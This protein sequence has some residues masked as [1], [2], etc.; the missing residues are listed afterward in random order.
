MKYLS[1]VFCISIS[2]SLYSQ[3][4]FDYKQF[5]EKMCSPE[6]QGRGYVNSGDSIAAVF[7]A[8]QLNRLGLDS[9]STGYFQPFD[10]KVNTFPDTCSVFLGGNKLIPGKD[11]IVAPISGGS[12]DPSHCAPKLFNV[13]FISGKNFIEMKGLNILEKLHLQTEDILVIDN[14][15]YSS[16]STREISYL[17]REYARKNHVIEAVSNKF[18]WSVT[19]LKNEHLYLQMKAPLFQN[20]IKGL[21]VEIHLHN[22]YLAPHTANNVLGFIPSRKKAKGTILLTAHYDHLGRLGSETYFPGGNDNASGVAMM[23][24]L[25]VLIKQ[26]PLKKYNTILVAFAGE[27]IGLL[28]SKYLS[29]N[30]LFDLDKVRFLLNLDIMGSGEEGITAVNGSVFKKEFRKLQKLNKKL[31]AVPVVK[32]RGKAANSDHY[33]FT[34][35][36]ITSFF[37]YTM[38][39][40]KNYHDIYDTYDALSFQSFEKLSLLFNKFLRK[41]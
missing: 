16:D 3:A 5:T 9:L 27:E 31:K 22:V 39:R 1:F 36:G 38:G 15:V 18:T 41:L 6:F 25:G 7:I 4:D 10:F 40:N 24:Q 21:K 11:F 29:E 32:A 34:E 12:C 33:F 19:S 37:V 8:Q 35:K 28:G 14:S 23:L 13:H 20:N 2:L 17:I 30:P 26:T